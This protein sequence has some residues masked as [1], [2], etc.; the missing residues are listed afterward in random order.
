[1]HL[2]YFLLSAV[3]HTIPSLGCASICICIVKPRLAMFSPILFS[4]SKVA[5]SST[6][7]WLFTYLRTY[8]S[9]MSFNTC[10]WIRGHCN[11]LCIFPELFLFISIIYCSIYD[12]IPVGYTNAHMRY[13]TLVYVNFKTACLF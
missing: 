12:A 4:E 7:R 2:Q 10:R 3:N 8:R 11:Q 6:R 13:V 5:Q 1:M 9:V